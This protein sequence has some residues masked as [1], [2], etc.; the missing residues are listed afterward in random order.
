MNSGLSGIER[1]RIA[2]LAI[3]VLGLLAGAAGAQEVLWGEPVHEDAGYAVTQRNLGQGRPEWRAFLEAHPGVWQS[4]WDLRNGRPH[5]LL[6]PGIP[7]ESSGDLSADTA[8]EFALALLAQ[9]ADLFGVAAMEPA[10]S[11]PVI[12]AGNNLILNLGFTRDGIP[13][14]ADTRVGFRFKT[15]GVLAAIVLD[16]LPVGFEPP[17]PTTE[18]ASALETA[19]AASQRALSGLRVSVPPRLEYL[20]DE[21][22]FGRLVWRFELRDDDLADPFVMDY[23]VHARGDG[24]VLRARTGVHYVDLQGKVEGRPIVFDPVTS[25]EVKPLR[26]LL[27]DITSGGSGQAYTDASGNFTIPFGGSGTV[28]VRSQL[29]GRWANAN[30]QAGSDEVLTKTAT[31]PGPFDFLHNPTGNDEYLTAQSNGYYHTT[32]IHQWVYD[33]LGPTN[34]DQL[35]VV[36]VNISSTCNAYYNGSINFFRSGGGCR[37]TAYDTVIYHE[38]GHY[39]DAAFGGLHQPYSE[40]IGDAFAMYI[41]DQPIVGENFTTGGG[42]VRTGENTRQWPASECGGEVHCVGEVLTGA[43]WKLRINLQSSLGTEVGGAVADMLLALMNAASPLTIPDAGI[44]LF[45]ADDDDG[46]LANATP[47]YFEI[48]AALEAH[49]LP[50][51]DP[52]FIVQLDHMPLDNT[53]DSAQARP[54]VTAATAL[55]GSITSV[56]LHW[57]V[58]GGAFGEAAMAPTGNPDEYAAEIPA[59]PCGSEVRYYLTAEDDRGFSGAYP[60]GAPALTSPILYVVGRKIVLYGEDFEDLARVANDWYFLPGSDFEAGAPNQNGDN[61][62]DPLAAS[63]GQYVIGTDLNSG[64]DDGNYASNRFTQARSPAVDC[65]GP[66]KLYLG[67]RRW[68]SV[69]DASKD[70]AAILVESST[71]FGTVWSNP[72]QSPVN[73]NM[74]LVDTAWIPWTCDLSALAAGDPEVNVYF[75]ILS[76]AQGTFGGWNL[77]DVEIFTV[78]CA[79]VTLTIDNPAPSLGQPVTF[80]TEGAPGGEYWLLSARGT[81]GGTFE[82]PGGPIV[83]TGLDPATQQLRRDSFLD[84]NGTD[85]WTKSVPTNPG[86]IGKTFYFV[87][88]SDNEGYQASS[89]ASLTIAN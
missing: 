42:Y 75:R 89:V 2:I 27:V 53:Q 31:P 21:E 66:S 36:N 16:N 78:S 73:G 55:G 76:D 63:S 80:T 64:D 52:P 48:R 51:I 22:M 58:D 20:P 37:N 26:D 65:S 46:V 85:A 5:W 62:W 60:V 38:Y 82:V 8:R 15:H 1:G 56:K 57:S 84:G 45:I 41:T 7:V 54:V 59:Q 39:L 34:A 23:A 44:E 87:S 86:L 32:L 81:G 77:D 35:M 19:R 69:Q 18:A 72:A 47:H 71:S 28:S 50:Y 4:F 83:E 10:A 25:P 24:E 17:V 67:F 30:N 6:G 33:L 79:L 68:L 14:D 3:V 61:P 12:V 40:G 49:N 74:D 13:V 29:Q 43:M 88:V 70:L 9:H 11:D